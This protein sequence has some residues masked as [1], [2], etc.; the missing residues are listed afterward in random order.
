[1]KPV[2]I[3]R[4]DKAGFFQPLDLYEKKVGFSRHSR[5]KGRDELESESVK[6]LGS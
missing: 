2:Y 4:N 6:S 5:E 1:M 3:L